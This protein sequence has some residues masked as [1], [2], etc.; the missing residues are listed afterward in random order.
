MTCPWSEVNVDS[1]LFSPTMIYYLMAALDLL[2]GKTWST[3]MKDQCLYL[4]ACPSTG[5]E[6]VEP[7]S[8]SNLATIGMVLFQNSFVGGSPM[9]RKIPSDRFC[10][11]CFLLAKPGESWCKVKGK[12]DNCLCDK[13]YGDN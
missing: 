6:F 9:P 3:E 8:L 13:C 2:N 11:K 7:Y 10:S 4:P 12:D 1:L 5:I